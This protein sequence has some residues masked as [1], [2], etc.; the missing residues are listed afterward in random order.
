M[1]VCAPQGLSWKPACAMTLRH[2]GATRYLV[3][4]VHERERRR[5]D[6]DDRIADDQGAG[7]PE[8]G[9]R[10]LLAGLDLDDGEIGD[11]VNPLSGSSDRM[12]LQASNT[13]RDAQGRPKIKLRKHDFQ[14]GWFHE[15]AR[16]HGEHSVEVRQC[17]ELV[18]EQGQTYLNLD[19]D[20][21]VEGGP[22]VAALV[23]A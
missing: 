22:S 5:A 10:Q 20:S 7:L 6:G 13:K 23:A 1:R 14:V 15:I 21:E 11:R 12:T 2:C 18:S 3:G 9:G 8:R 19:S 4:S 17:R 16:R